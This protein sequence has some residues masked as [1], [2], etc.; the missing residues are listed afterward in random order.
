MDIFLQSLML[1]LIVVMLFSVAIFIYNIIE[2]GDFNIIF[3]FTLMIAIALF[4]MSYEVLKF[5]VSSEYIS[6]DR[7]SND[8]RLDYI[9]K[10]TVED[11]YNEDDLDLIYRITYKIEDTVSW[12]DNCR[13]SYNNVRVYIDRE[14]NGIKVTYTCTENLKKV[15]LFTVKTKRAIYDTLKVSNK[16]KTEK[17]NCKK[18]DVDDNKT[19]IDDKNNDKK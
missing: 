10:N 5:D 2:D 15:G 16:N 14:D 11:Y 1:F 4:I 9:I 19:E 17:E 7:Y 18:K 3:I 6:G 8:L 13:V 12:T